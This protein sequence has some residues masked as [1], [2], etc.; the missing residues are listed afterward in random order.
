[1]T[2]RLLMIALDGADSDLIDRRSKDGT[3]PNLSALRARGEARALTAPPGVTDDALW[4]SFQFAQPLGEHGRYNYLQRL[5]DGRIGMAF[6]EEADRLWFW[7]RLSKEGRRVAVLDIPKTAE[8][9]PINGIHLADWLVHGKYFDQ[10]LSYPHD[11][12]AEIVAKFGAA[13]PSRCGHPVEMTDAVSEDV[14]SHLLHSIDMKRDAGRQYLAAEDWDLFMIGF[15]EAHCAGHTFWDVVDPSHPDFDAARRDRLGDP[16]GAV[17]ARLDTA[18][19]TLVEAAG[20]GASIVVFSTTRMEPNASLKHLHGKLGRRLNRT[21]AETPVAQLWRRWRKQRA[22]IEIMPFNENGTAIRINVD[23]TPAARARIAA[24]VAA[25]FEAL[26]DAESGEPLVA[27]ID[28]PAE[29]SPGARSGNLPDLLVRYRAG[30]FPRAVTAPRL[31]RVEAEMP[32]YRAGNH[33]AGPFAVAAG[34]DLG[35]VAALEDFGPLA[36][37]VL[38]R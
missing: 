25:T 16:V 23:R 5:G 31:G 26:T 36:E 30:H 20:P 29:D 28:R 9:R 24:R 13:P 27:A 18:V 8:P 11:L 12:A 19:G 2:A 10:P 4:A 21:H 17:F 34:L 15:K 33:A 37:R 1:M 32:L 14:A 3:L 35:T 38:A 6:T 7:E 22:P